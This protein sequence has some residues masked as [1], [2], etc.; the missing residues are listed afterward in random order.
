MY[1]P[2]QDYEAE[3]DSK[4]LKEISVL[5]DT[6]K[7]VEEQMIKEYEERKAVNLWQ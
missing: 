2:F 4:Y 1:D 5:Q 7:F 3:L 6:E